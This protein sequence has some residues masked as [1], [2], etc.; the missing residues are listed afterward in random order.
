M[1]RF[2]VAEEVTFTISDILP[3]NY[4]LSV[5][6]D[7]NN[8]KELDKG[9]FIGIYGE[10]NLGAYIFSELQVSEGETFNCKIDMWILDF[11]TAPLISSFQV[12]PSNI[13][14][15]N[16]Q[17]CVEAIDPTMTFCPISTLSMEELSSDQVPTY[18]GKYL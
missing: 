18:N 4:Y 5:W 8:S 12:Y 14:S 11:N 9:D 2:R 17:M 1:L 16:G 15:D 7:N 10:I 3:G 13:T 6:K